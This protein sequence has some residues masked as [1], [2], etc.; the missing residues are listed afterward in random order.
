M[1]CKDY[2]V[3]IWTWHILIKCFLSDTFSWEYTNGKE[4]INTSLSPF[5]NKSINHNQ[6][7]KAAKIWSV[8]KNL[9]F[10]KYFFV[11]VLLN[12]KNEC[13]CNM[14]T[15]FNHFFFSYNFTIYSLINQFTFNTTCWLNWFCRQYI[16]PGG[17][18]SAGPCPVAPADRNVLF[19][20]RLLGLA[21]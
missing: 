11:I 8:I 17:E 1:I 3:H 16:C 18:E 2:S 13:I 7:I 20:N 10:K 6:Y 15:M 19:E 14:M 5:K 12:T 9:T 21:R 4:N